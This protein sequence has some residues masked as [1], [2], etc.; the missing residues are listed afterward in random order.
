MGRAGAFGVTVTLE[1]DGPQNVVA[2]TGP[3][4]VPEPVLAP[5]PRRA[6]VLITVEDNTS[7]EDTVGDEDG[8]TEDGEEGPGGEEGGLL[9]LLAEAAQVRQ[10]ERQV[11]SMFIACIIELRFPFLE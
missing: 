4:R 8:A 3:A 10:D 6:F 5:W 1:A 11:Q 2:A 9:R 7:G